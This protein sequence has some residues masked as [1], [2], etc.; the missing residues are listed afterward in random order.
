MRRVAVNIVRDEH[1][2]TVTQTN[3][4][5]RM[6]IVPVVAGPDTTEEF[7]DMVEP[8]PP[9]QKSAVKLFYRD[10]FSTDEGA[11]QMGISPGAFRFHLIRA[12]KALAPQIAEPVNYQ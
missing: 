4:L 9:R 1:R 5:P 11:A 6:A 7:D 8:L 2:K 12:R 10:G 3:A